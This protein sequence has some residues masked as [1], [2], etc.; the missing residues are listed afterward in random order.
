M[1]PLE[2]AIKMET[3]GK[4]FYETASAKAGD[5]LGKTLF[6]RLATE[7]DYHA[8]KAREI[9]ENLERGETP[10]GI[11]GYLD[12]G[13][14]IM[15]IFAKAKKRISS[16]RNVASNELQAIKLALEMEERSGK[17]YEEQ[18]KTAKTQYERQYF[19]ELKKE[20]RGHYLA[21]ID[22]REYLIDPTGWFFKSEHISLDGG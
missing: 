5:D 8:A 18:S 15:T 3:E 20:E 6:A 2:V 17:F 1:N 16:K 7:E 10:L 12:D 9:Y 14:N 22:Y 13:K 11:D 21:L 4:A 19:G